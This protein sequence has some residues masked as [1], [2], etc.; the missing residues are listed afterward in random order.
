MVSTTCVVQEVLELGDG[1]ESNTCVVKL[2][3]ELGHSAPH[4]C[5]EDDSCT[6]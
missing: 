6:W 2:L 5:G 4:L 1:E 3:L